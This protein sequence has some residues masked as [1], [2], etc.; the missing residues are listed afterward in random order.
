MEYSY[1]INTS[2]I[3]WFQIN[4]QI[5]R[6]FYLIFAGKED[7]EGSEYAGEGSAHSDEGEAV[8]DGD[9]YDGEGGVGSDE[10]VE[11]ANAE[12]LGI[13]GFGVAHFVGPKGVVGEDVGAGRKRGADEVEVFGVA[14]LVG[15]DEDEVVCVAGE[16]VGE[17]GLGVAYVDGYV[18][19]ARRIGECASEVVGIDVVDFDGVDAAAFGHAFG[20]AE[21]GIAGEGAEFENAPWGDELR[22][23]NEEAALGVVG[24][25]AGV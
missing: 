1:I 8:A 16:E 15:V 20:E 25:H 6:R 11:S 5:I 21:C 17:E 12:G 13:G 18:G 3:S 22:E 9:Y 23:H 19:T 10:V 2:K 14:A 7:S 24:A 4:I